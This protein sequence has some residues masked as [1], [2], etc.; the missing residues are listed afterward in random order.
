MK[1][2]A[3]NGS[4]K[5]D[6]GNTALILAPFLDG[7][8]EAGA[9]VDLLYTS[10]LNI[11]PC[12]GDFN[13]WLKTPGKCHQ[14]D[15][16]QLVHPK[17]READVWVFASPV[18]VWGIT[19]PLKNL[20]D[21][22]IPLVEPFIYL[23]Q[24]HCSHPPRPDTKR[25]KIVL[26]SNCGFWE[27]DNFD[28]LLAQMQTWCR[29]IGLEFAGALLRPAGPLL[30]AMLEMGA[31]VQDV[32][33]AA[34]DAGRQLVRDGAISQQALQVVSRDLMPRDSYIQLIN[35]NFQQAL[36]SVH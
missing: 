10:K 31:P 9:D 5:M 28:P 26:V 14:Q 21:R 17:L 24:G 36:A 12:L 6:K 25:S 23:N 11:H 7:L 19:G 8:R 3:F 32:L 22:I 16:M 35:Q 15:D 27:M 13:C 29:I 20:I 2:L 4:P 30:A 1:V 18:Y 33:D 34:R